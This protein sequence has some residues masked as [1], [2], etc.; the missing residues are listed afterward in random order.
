[1]IAVILSHNLLGT[2]RVIPDAKGQDELEQ[3]IKRSE[4]ND[5]VQYEYS[6]DLEFTKQAGNFLDQAYL[7]GGRLQ[8]L[9]VATIY[10]YDPNKFLWEQIGTGKIKFSNHEKGVLVF[11][12]SIEQTGF[13]KKVLNQM[14]IDVDL[15]TLVSQGGVP[16]SETPSV[17]LTLHAKKVLEEYKARPSDSNEYR[18]GD[19]MRFSI[20][21]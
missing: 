20:S 16:L 18:Q 9:V 7:L 11:K 14:D 6:L 8:S 10:E 5:G 13:E 15:D 17:N 19:V 12:T 4:E 3:T 21:G 2:I 1:M